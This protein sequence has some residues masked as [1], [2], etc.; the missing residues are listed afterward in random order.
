MKET[1]YALPF[2]GIGVTALALIQLLSMVDQSLPIT[3][4]CFHCNFSSN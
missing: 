1:G 4:I 3:R 2:M